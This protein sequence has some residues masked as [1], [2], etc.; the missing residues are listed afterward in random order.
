MDSGY[1][2][3]CDVEKSGC[4][5]IIPHLE[6]KGFKVI[7]FKK[8]EL[9]VHGDY[10]VQNGGEPYIIEIKTEKNFTGNFFFEIWSNKKRGNPGWIYKLSADWLL[11]YFEENCRLY[12]MHVPVLKKI[13]FD[14]EI[15]YQYKEKRQNKYQQK[16]DTWGCCVPINAIMGHELSEGGRYFKIEE[17][18]PF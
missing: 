2:Q 7:P 9:Q 17:V 13:L 5:I 6:G 15:I 3:A 10:I 16:N 14:D 4:K 12:Y 8:K 18:L 11:Y 1:Q